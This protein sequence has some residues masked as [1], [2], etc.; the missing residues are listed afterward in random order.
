MF[1]ICHPLLT[2]YMP[3]AALS[4]NKPGLKH[5][6][7]NCLGGSE[8]VLSSL[9]RLNISTLLLQLDFFSAKLSKETE[10][11]IR[12]TLVSEAQCLIGLLLIIFVRI[13]TYCY[14]SS[15]SKLTWFFFSHVACFSSFSKLTWL[16]FLG[17]HT[18]G[19]GRISST[20]F[21]SQTSQ[22]RLHPFVRHD[23]QEWQ[24]FYPF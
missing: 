14:T 13:H 1:S 3:V 21:E 24:T 12:R 6:Q 7:M 19:P 20:N 8:L 9:T 16:V 15:F 4:L 5:L 2:I 10:I 22:V 17:E 18:P 11:E 23:R